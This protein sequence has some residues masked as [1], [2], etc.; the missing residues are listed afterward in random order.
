MSQFPISIYY[1]MNKYSYFNSGNAVKALRTMKKLKMLLVLVTICGG[2][3]PLAPAQG[4]LGLGSAGLAGLPDTARYGDTFQNLHVWVV[5]RGILPLTNVLVQIMAAPNQGPAVQLGTL[6]L[7]LGILNPGDSMQVPMDDYTVTP[8]NSAQGSNVIVVWPIAPGTQPE[9]SATDDYWVEEVLSVQESS[10]LHSR[11]QIYPNPATTICFVSELGNW[12]PGQL[13][14][15]Y[16]PTGE[17]MGSY[18][19]PPSGA[20]DISHL[21]PRLY[22][23]RLEGNSANAGSGRLLIQQ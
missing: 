6:D 11:P 19:I 21:Q 2:L 7:T 1:M 22:L 4:L 17:S 18:S 10:L 16:L 14:H 13:L 9:D 12:Q 20:V 23:Y 15:L 8:Q 5:N 3:L